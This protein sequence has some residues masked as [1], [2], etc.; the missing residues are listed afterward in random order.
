MKTLIG[1]ITLLIIYSVYNWPP[2]MDATSRE[3]GILLVII[4]TPITLAYIFMS[5]ADWSRNCYLERKLKE[6]GHWT[7]K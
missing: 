7:N 1:I 6:E 5:I 2:D 3:A 4:L